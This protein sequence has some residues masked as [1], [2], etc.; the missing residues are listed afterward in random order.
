[1]LNG[2]LQWKCGKLVTY[3][4]PSLDHIDTFVGGSDPDERKSSLVSTGNCA[5]CCKFSVVQISECLTDCLLCCLDCNMC[6]WVPND[7]MWEHSSSFFDAAKLTLDHDPLHG[8]DVYDLVPPRFMAL[9]HSLGTLGSLFNPNF[10][11]GAICDLI[12]A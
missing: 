5:V 11:N 10:S 3:Q 7:D 2:V 6:F 12:I 1:M 8:S 4:V 9:Q